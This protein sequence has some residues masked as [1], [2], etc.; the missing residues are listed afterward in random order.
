[1]SAEVPRPQTRFTVHID[2]RG[3]F[4][5]VTPGD[6]TVHRETPRGMRMI[7]LHEPFSPF[8]PLHK[9]ETHTGG[10]LTTLGTDILMKTEL[11]LPSGRRL[12]SFLLTLGY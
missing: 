4:Y 12:P 9:T 6:E 5:P 8:L 7:G 10:G 3:G 11:H 1:M 2:R